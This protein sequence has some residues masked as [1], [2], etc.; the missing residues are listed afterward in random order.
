MFAHYKSL[1][2][3]LFL[4]LLSETFLSQVARFNH[5]NADNGLSYNSVSCIVQDN[6]GFIWVGTYNGLNKYD[7][8]KFTTIKEPKTTIDTILSMEII[9]CLYVDKEDNLWVGTNSSGIIQINLTTNQ[10]TQYNTDT[11]GTNAV[12]SNLINDIKELKD[13]YLHIATNKGLSVFNKKSKTFHNIYHDDKNANSLLSN[14]I[15][16]IIKDKT[17]H[18]WLG[19]SGFGLT[20][21]IPESDKYIRYTLSTHKDFL[22]GNKIRYLFCDSDGLIWISLWNS[23]LAIYDPSTKTF[24]SDLNITNFF[25]PFH[26]TVGLVS[27]IY[28]DANKNIWFCTAEKGLMKFNKKTNQLVSFKNNP[29]DPES[30]SDDNVLCI[31]ED[32]SG[33]IWA[34]TW[35]NGLNLFNPNSLLLGHQKHESNKPST[36]V[37]NNVL[38]FYPYNENEIIVATAGSFCFFNLT[39]KTFSDFNLQ[40]LKGDA[41]SEKTTITSVIKYTDGSY[42]FGTNGA[43]V[44]RYFPEKSFIKNYSYSAND[45]GSISEQTIS[46]LLLDKNNNIWISTYNSGLNLYNAKQDNFTHFLNKSGNEFYAPGIVSMM[47]DKEKKIWINTSD[48]G[49]LILNPDNYKFS[50]PFKNNQNYNLIQGIVFN[51]HCDQNGEVWLG[52]MGKLLQINSKTYKITDHTLNNKQLQLDYLNITK[53]NKNNIWITSREGIVKYSINNKTIKIFKSIDGAQGKEFNFNSVLKL[54][55]GYFLIGGTNGFNYFNPDEVSEKSNPPKVMLTGF[56]VLNKPYELEN[57]IAYTNQIKLNYKEYF[58]SIEFA[59]SNYSK[60]TENTFMY[61][62]VGF[63]H[64]WVEIGNQHQITFTNLNHGNYTLLIKGANNQGVWCTKPLELNITI[65]PPFWKTTWFY[66][67]CILLGIFTIYGFIKYREQ[68]LVKEKKIL[69]QKVD[70]R[71]NELNLEKQ[72]VEEA[73]NDIRD[74]IFYAQK[75]QQSIIPTESDFKKLLPNSFV[76]FKPKDIVSGDFYWI[77]E[78]KGTVFCAIADC[79][80]HGVPGGFMTMLGSG[81]LNE[82]TGEQNI[83]EPAEILNKLREKIISTLKQTGKEGENKDGMDIVILR[84]DLKNKKLSYAAANNGFILV[85]NKEFTEHYGNKQPVGIYGDALKP[86]NQ[87]ELEL[88]EGDTIYSYTD[89]YPDQFGGPK[90]K[91]F[92]YKT[93]NQALIDNSHLQMPYQKDKLDECFLNWKGD[94][95]QIDDVCIVGIKI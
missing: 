81:L 12:A 24:H 38:S 4:I 79:T 78:K 46:Q 47:E 94:L 67:V 82:I 61:K 60:P 76:L 59:A 27:S 87:F 54:P 45:T 10:K 70:E 30:I 53:D 11:I 93:L 6:K 34:G 3:F 48:K 8:Y 74:S 75:I 31:L 91:K 33:L 26:T 57:D 90:G 95:E 80:G 36:L 85:N 19:H 62:L 86:F 22:P 18:F 64:D 92:K 32:K 17:G 83:T 44:Y 13:G 25:K 1:K 20:E 23:N 9:K 28:E 51:S 55:N 52:W 43:G 16:T 69:E 73:H 58:F 72:K 63:N 65:T 15:K 68:K 88:K 84:I 42:W 89:G 49:V 14:S 77:T 7:G 41:M 40:K 39:T 71:T 56:S 66:T 21:Y 2:Y 50:S 29:D 37:N 35:K 5:L